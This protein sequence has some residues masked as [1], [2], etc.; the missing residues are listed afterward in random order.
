MKK[1]FLILPLLALFSCESSDTDP[2]QDEEIIPVVKDEL[3]ASV[4]NPN[5]LEQIEFRY[6]VKTDGLPMNQLYDSITFS[7]SGID[8]ELRVYNI[9]FEDPG[10]PYGNP[11]ET[12]RGNWYHHFI[13][14]GNYQAHL[15]GYKNNEKKTLDVVDFTVTQPYD[16]YNIDWNN[17]VVGKKSYFNEIDRIRLITEV[18]SVG[19][20]INPKPAV[21]VTYGFDDAY[22]PYSETK[23]EEAKAILY[24]NTVGAYGLP[25]YTGQDNLNDLFA[26]NFTANLPENEFIHDIWITE[27]SIIAL[28][29]V[30]TSDGMKLSYKLYA[31][32]R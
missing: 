2:I 30:R 21:E 16:F 7:V 29:D 11:A 15:Y 1:L 27:K 5:V 8:K 6:R 24:S 25:T 10:N 3:I 26:Q 14:A 12:A 20:Y 17:Y 28:L 4:S 13:A 32:K 19:N 23:N 22:W 31:E 18:K 9:A